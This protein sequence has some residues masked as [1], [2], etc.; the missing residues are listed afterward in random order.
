MYRY[1]F[2]V[3]ILAIS[4][5]AII[6]NASATGTHDAYPHYPWCEMTGSVPVVS[7]PVR[8][9]YPPEGE[10][11]SHFRPF[12]DFF[13]ISVLNSVLTFG[14]LLYYL[15]VKMLRCIFTK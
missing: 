6:S 1:F 9:Y 11:V 8:V 5:S 7:T 14:A 2:Q 3:L 4:L 12:W 10:R 13:R 15:P